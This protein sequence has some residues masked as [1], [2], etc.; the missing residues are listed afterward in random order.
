MVLR[1]NVGD[2][3]RINFQNYLANTVTDQEQA[4]T[5]WASIHVVGMQLVGGIGSDGSN[6]GSNVS[7]LVPPGGSAIYTLYG[8]K[9]GEHVLNSGGAVTGGEGDGGQINSGLFGALIV[10]PAG[11]RWYRSQVTRADMALA[12]TIVT[13]LGTPVIDYEARYPVGNPQ[14]G[15]LILNM[16]DGTQIVDTDLTAIIAGSAPNGGG[17]NPGWFPAGTFPANV[18]HPQREQ[19]FREFT[20]LYHDETGAVQAFPQFEDEV[21]SHTLHSGR[22]AFAINYGSAGVGAE[23]LANRIGV[24]PMAPCTECKFEEFFLSSWT[25]GDPAMV[26]DVPANAPCTV[27]NVR[28]AALPPVGFMP[29]TP[30]PGAKATKA[31]YPDDPSNVYHSYL[32]DHTRFRVLH[33]GSKEHHIHHLHAHQWLYSGDSDKSAY[34]D[35]QALGPGSSF[36]AEITHEGSGNKNLTP[37]DSI[38]HCHFYPHFAQGMWAL[39]RVHDVFESGT[40]LDGNGRPAGVL[41]RPAGRR[42]RRRHAHPGP[43]PPARQADGARSRR[44]GLD[45][46]RPG[47]DHRHG[48]PR[49]P[50][51]RAGQGRAPPAASAARHPHRRRPA[52]PHHHRRHLQRGAH[53]HRLPQNAAHRHRGLDPRGRHHRRAAGLGLPRPARPPDLHAGRRVRRHDQRQ[54]RHQ[55]PAG[56]GRARRSPTPA[57]TPPARRRPPTCAPT[58]PPTSSWTSSSTRPAGT[59][60]SS[61]SSPSGRTSRAT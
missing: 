57:S 52:A 31:F 2:C 16:L 36:T 3:L 37:G 49:L 29:C 42:N 44:R 13:T 46:G 53:P 10:E 34:L 50:V 54:V 25:V 47:P 61:A 28:D 27:Q 32:R 38:F 21:L 33:A 1:M 23:V 43:G 60:R 9:E 45:R 7:S 22:D 30:T 18:T 48:Q 12:T 14:A 19:P 58:R 35:S 51:L 6:V 8:D 24:G 20:I 40:A 39:W 26:V 11:S 15:K 17:A 4:A 56:R 41:P 5:R 55:R 59:T